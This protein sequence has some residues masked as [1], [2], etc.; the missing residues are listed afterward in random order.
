M[1]GMQEKDSIKGEGQIKKSEPRDHS[2]TAL[3][4]SHEAR[5]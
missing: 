3:G 5:Q 4:M 1:K 2:L